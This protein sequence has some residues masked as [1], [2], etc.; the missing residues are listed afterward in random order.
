MKL[1]MVF[2]LLLFLMSSFVLADTYS[3]KNGW[4]YY[5]GDWSTTIYST[6]MA[7]CV[8][9]AALWNNSALTAGSIIDNSRCD[10]LNNGVHFSYIDVMSVTYCPGGGTVSGSNCINAPACVSPQVRSSSTGMCEAP[11]SPPCTAG[12]TKTLLIIA[13]TYPDD[14]SPTFALNHDRTAVE[15]THT[16]V[17]Q[18]GCTYNLPLNPNENTGCEKSPSGIVYC[19]VM[20]TQTGGIYTGADTA[21]D[22]AMTGNE[23]IGQAKKGCYKFAGLDEVCLTSQKKNCGSVNGSQLCVNPDGGLTSNGYSAVMINGQ[24]VGGTD[25]N[26]HVKNCYKNSNNSPTCIELP[27][28][29]KGTCN[30]PSFFV[31]V[32][33]EKTANNLTP[34]TIPLSHNVKVEKT[35]QTTSNADG[36]TTSITHTSD[37]VL[38]S[39]PGTTTTTTGSDGNSTT[40]TMGGGYGS[41]SGSGSGIGSGSGDGGEQA[42]NCDKYPDSVGCQDVSG[43]GDFVADTNTTPGQVAVTTQAVG[44]FSSTGTCPASQTFTVFNKS[45]S[46]PWT[47]VCSFASQLK[48]IILVVASIGALMIIFSVA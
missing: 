32:E 17:D 1:K 21:L 25:T 40:T 47:P 12:Q 29:P 7:A 5:S 18:G 15:Q 45:Y 46:I 41:G 10:A 4:K 31:C 14:T 11:P 3:V 34:S 16:T 19:R 48:P 20:A 39:N 9:R 28:V 13:G 44:G 8:A 24:V 2:G 26:G 38:G 23:P 35:T 36:S 37:N 22:G 33:P 6:Q 27:I 43:E 30:G 42:V